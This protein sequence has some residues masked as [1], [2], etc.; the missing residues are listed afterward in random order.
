M[1]Q[2]HGEAARLALLS[3]LVVPSHG[4]PPPPGA[5]GGSA[6]RRQGAGGADGGEGAHGKPLDEDTK[7]QTRHACIMHTIISFFIYFISIYHLKS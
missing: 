1:Q 2:C 7:K 6:R 4:E 3:A 5:L